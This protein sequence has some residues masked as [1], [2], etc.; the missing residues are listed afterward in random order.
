MTMTM[1]SAAA[2]PRTTFLPQAGMLS[3]FMEKE[4]DVDSVGWL[5]DP[6]VEPAGE[7]QPQEL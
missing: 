1:T 3:K 2:P 7:G 5:K 6:S 4:V